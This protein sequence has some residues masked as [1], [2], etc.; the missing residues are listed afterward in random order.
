M[1]QI[2]IHG[3]G[4]QGGKTAS[5]IIGTAAFMDGK[6]VQDFPKYGAERRGAP[7][8]SFTRIDDKPIESR[9]YIY[10]PDAVIGLDESLMEMPSV[11][12]LDG[13]KKEGYLIINSGESADL[14]KKKYKVNAKV[15][16]VNATDIALEILGKPIPNAVI[17]GA[18]AKVT[19]I[20]SM[21]SLKK[22]IEHEL[23]ARGT[24]SR[25]IID[26]NI[27]GAEK[28]AEVVKNG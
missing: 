8:F 25:D 28:C 11:G 23:E 13:L 16:S 12:V 19:K 4:G 24:I 27:S 6:F 21:N 10:E 1:Y 18:F 3:R 2:R 26:K 17:T 5:K 9:G 15:V 14:I 7:V 22:A 20:V